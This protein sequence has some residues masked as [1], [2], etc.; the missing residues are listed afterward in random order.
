MGGT[1]INSLPDDTP[2][3]MDKV[4]RREARPSSAITSEMFEG[5]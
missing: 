3:V 1:Q 4:L 5:D 2:E